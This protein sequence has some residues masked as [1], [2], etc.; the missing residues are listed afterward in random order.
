MAKATY[1]AAG[2]IIFDGMILCQLWKKS[3]NSI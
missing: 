3:A 2:G 1:A